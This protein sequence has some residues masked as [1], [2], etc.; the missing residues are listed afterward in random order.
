VKAKLP[1]AFSKFT[2]E[3]LLRYI[4]KLN[5]SD[6]KDII[7][8][9]T[10]NAGKEQVWE[11][12]TDFEEYPK[13]NPFLIQ[14]AGKLNR[15]DLTKV[16]IRVPNVPEEFF[17]YATIK[18]EI[19]GQRLVWRSRLYAKELFAGRHVF[20]IQEVAENKVV[21]THQETYTGVLIFFI[22]PAFFGKV[23]RGINAMNNALKKRAENLYNKY[24]LSED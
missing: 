4:G 10:I 24:M 7:T 2:E 22:D 13:W 5:I 1:S 16:T 20:D 12:L 6:D 18:K 15:K 14:I 23:K 21:L 3:Y 17:Y 19:P 8:T 9:V 11:V